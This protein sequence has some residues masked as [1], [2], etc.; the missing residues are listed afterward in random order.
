MN[1]LEVLIICGR[2]TNPNNEPTTNTVDFFLCEKRD[3]AAAKVFFDK[4]IG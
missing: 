3:E 2:V 4:V 1:D